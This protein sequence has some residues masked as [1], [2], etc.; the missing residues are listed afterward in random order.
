MQACFRAIPAVDLCLAE[1][2]K[3]GEDVNFAPPALLRDLV[4]AFWE[5][6]RQ[7]IRA[8]RITRAAEAGLEAQFPALLAHIR[9]GI[10]PYLRRVLNG[11]GVV[12]HTN[13]GR[14]VLA[15]E[16]VAA[17]TMAASGYC[18]LEM[19]LAT[20][21]RGSRHAVTE[22][23][24]KRLTGAEAALVVNNNAA[25]VF[26]VLD[27][28]CK[29]G[30]VIV[31]RGE[32]VEIGGSFRIPDIMAKSGAT[33]REVGTT[34]RTHLKD[35]RE[36][37]GPET[38]ALMRVHTSNYRIIGFHAEADLADLAGLASES[39]LPLLFDLGS[40]SLLEFPGLPPEPTVSRVV[41][42]GADCVT[43][44]GDK[45]L[46]GPQA[47]IIVGKREIVD[48]LKKNPLCRALRCCKLTL[49]ALEATLRLYLEPERARA[50]VPTAAMISSGP[51]ELREA[52]SA[53][54]EAALKELE[55]A[56][57]ECAV[58]LVDAS[59]RV[60]GGAFPECDLPTTL[61]SFVPG[62]GSATALRDRLLEADPPL[63]GRLEQ[64]SFCIDPRCLAR[65]D[66][67][68]AAGCIAWALNALKRERSQK[69]GAGEWKDGQT[70]NT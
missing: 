10:R 50:G 64:D 31:S 6:R 14:S 1:L 26:L 33:L 53:F 41:S 23:L 17:V 7:D 55:A 22:D 62:Y 30:E 5:E 56:D 46:G 39:G 58:S 48:R 19:D 35:Y 36:A 4:A 27:T 68:T 67:E 9:K 32:L 47:G 61:V 70:A 42:Q 43:F 63:I 49:S 15:P 24:L 34:N 37:I 52:A 60:G 18:N 65:S 12:I 20:G 29:G 13:L 21:N 2:R 16:A 40:G 8:G 45:V 66:F 25:A 38:K 11:A 51:H 28:L 44:S 69:S 59:S 54:Q 3:A 57:L